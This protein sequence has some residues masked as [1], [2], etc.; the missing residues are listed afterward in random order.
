[1]V[2]ALEEEAR[3]VA[4]QLLQKSLI[5]PT[6]PQSSWFPATNLVEGKTSHAWST[7]SHA[8]ACLVNDFACLVKFGG[9]KDFACLRLRI[10]L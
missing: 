3:A 8:F 1:M 6:Q 5:S 10:N 9:G 2:G 4:W 7:T